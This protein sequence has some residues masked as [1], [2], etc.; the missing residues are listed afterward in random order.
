MTV[1][2]TGSATA[3]WE[4][5]NTAKESCR[6]GSFLVACLAVAG[7]DRKQSRQGL[8]EA[9]AGKGLAERVVVVSD[10][11]AALSAAV[12]G[13]RGV[14]VI[15]G[16]GSVAY[17]INERG[18]TSRSGGWGWLLGDEGSGYDIGRKAL[19]AAL[20]AGDGRGD[21]NALTDR[22]RTWFGIQDLGD[23]VDL[24][25][26]KGLRVNDIAALT[27]LV[28]DAAKEGDNVAR[29]ILAEAGKELAQTVLAVAKD[30]DLKGVFDIAYTGGVF[31]LSPDLLR[32]F[33]E[34][35]FAEAPDCRILPSPF[36]PVV[37]AVFLALRE[38]GIS[39]DGKLRANLESSLGKELDT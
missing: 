6:D 10:A 36:E 25:Y 18:K 29:R 26:V 37:G 31:Q 21:P 23:L 20:R 7:V 11:R 39:V 35:V 33:S 2:F 17:G 30:L 19:S 24:A 1:G 9:V 28:A 3:V 27:G 16:T 14:V 8:L 12:L 4:A 22:L 5:V 15:S 38:A 32:S 34:N 13:D